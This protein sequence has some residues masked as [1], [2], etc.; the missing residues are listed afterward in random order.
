MNEHPLHDKIEAY[1][2]GQMPSAEAKSFGQEIAADEQLA[3][4]VEL[5]RL[6]HDAMNLLLEKDLKS[7]MATWDGSPPPNPFEGQGSRSKSFKFWL[8][9]ALVALL[10]VWGIYQFSGTTEQAGTPSTH[11]PDPAPAE[12]VPSAPAR[13]NTGD[14]PPVADSPT[15]GTSAPNGKKDAPQPVIDD[16]PKSQ[17]AFLALAASTYEAPSFQSN[18]RGEGKSASILEEASVAFGEAKYQAV[19]N[20]LAKPEAGNESLVRYLRGHAYFKTGKYN[21]AAGEFKPVASDEFLP[22]YQEAQWF[23]LLSYLAQLPATKKEFEALA[24]RLAA[25][26]YSDY[27]SKAKALLE[28]VAAMK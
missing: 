8:P 27:Q 14:T 5:Q 3:L 6:E 2:T 15:K 16:K 24:N 4:A 17:S 13:E 23:L 12:N 26:K 25:D 11:W 21:A 22:D 9:I 18:Q 19:L 1:L 7:K 20:L 10:A 28:K